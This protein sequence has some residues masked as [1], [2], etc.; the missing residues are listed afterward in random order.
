MDETYERHEAVTMAASAAGAADRPGDPENPGSAEEEQDQE[1]AEAV[2]LLLL[3]EERI[4]SYQRA[5]IA[6]KTRTAQ[7]RA[8]R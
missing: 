4:Q 2:R 6:P 5:E 3:G 7:G 8:A 1:E